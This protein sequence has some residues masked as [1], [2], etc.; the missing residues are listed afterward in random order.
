[1]VTHIHSICNWTL[2]S[3][4]KFTRIIVI[5]AEG[6]TGRSTKLHVWT[7][8][9]LL[10]W[11]W[12]NVQNR[13]PYPLI[14]SIT[15]SNGFCTI[16]HQQLR[17]RNVNTIPNCEIMEDTSCG[18]L[19]IYDEIQYKLAQVL[20]RQLLTWILWLNSWVAYET[21]TTWK[22]WTKPRWWDGQT[23]R[24]YHQ[25]SFL[26]SAEFLRHCPLPRLGKWLFAFDVKLG[27][28]TVRT[29][30]QNLARIL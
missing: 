9:P 14:L 25:N 5:F 20:P 21:A 11:V 23:Q 2:G 17:L 19:G 10:R 12:R 15:T 7:W 26:L 1:M 24:R 4:V 22:T 16:L 6:R 28:V 27:L 18:L 30:G 8:C 3:G 29:S 13:N